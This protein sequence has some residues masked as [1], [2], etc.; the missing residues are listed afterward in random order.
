MSA[1]LAQVK[2]QWH[3]LE[4]SEIDPIWPYI[5]DGVATAVAEA[6]GEV[7]TK[8]M[9]DGLRSGAMSILLM[10]RG[11][12]TVGVVFKFMHY[13]QFKIARVLLLFGERMA[14]VS[15]IMERAE[16]WAKSNGCKFVEGWV[17]TRSR[18]RLFS[19]FGYQ[20]VYT[21]VRKELT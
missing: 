14:G 21:I 1:V 20:E 13:P 9:R 11:A 5:E 10:S 16:Q 6:H 15:G 3:L 4:T 2:E 12:A 8:D 7:T 18:Q 19:R 17:S